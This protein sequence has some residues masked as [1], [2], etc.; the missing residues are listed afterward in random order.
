MVDQSSKR[1]VIIQ[2]A[3]KTFL[4]NGYAATS[5]NQVAE[6]AGVIKATIYSHFADKKQLFKAVI[7]EVVLKK[8]GADL[9]VV[10]EKL[11]KLTSRR[12]F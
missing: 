3:V 4:E 11:Q 5:M 7:E 1:D 2:A 10:E 6:E 9:E 12:I 8:A